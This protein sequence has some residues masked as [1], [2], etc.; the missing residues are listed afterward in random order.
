[1]IQ[2]LQSKLVLVV[3]G[4]ILI[5]SVTAVFHYQLESM[6]REELENRCRKISRVI[7]EMDRADFEE[8]KQSI[9]FDE[10]SQGIYLSPHIRGDPYTIEIRTD[11][12]RIVK[13]GESV[14]EGLEANVHTWDPRE[15][16]NT[17]ELGED[18]KSWRDS[19]SSPLV[20]RSGSE[21]IE[22]W[23][24]ELQDGDS[25]RSHIFV[26]EEAIS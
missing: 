19:K 18:E 4:T 11:F 21:E 22:L 14:V 16:N 5:S 10:G 2:W 12:V 6:E 15:M 24:I 8:M 17:G 9:T 13:D 23:K 26:F 25:T 7:E 1:M 3:V 20:V